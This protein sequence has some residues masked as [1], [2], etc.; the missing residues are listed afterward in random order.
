MFHGSRRV[1][2]SKRGGG[3]IEIAVAPDHPHLPEYLEFLKVPLT[4]RFAPVKAIDVERINGE[5]AVKSPYAAV[6]RELFA[7]TRERS[8]LRLRRRY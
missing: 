1:V 3:E 6:L 2:V 5:S 8:G 4:R 7:V